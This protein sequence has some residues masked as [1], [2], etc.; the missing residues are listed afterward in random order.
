MW[1]DRNKTY[2]LEKRFKELCKTYDAGFM[3]LLIQWTTSNPTPWIEIDTSEWTNLPK[4]PLPKGGEKITEKPGYLF[5]LNV[6]G[7]MFAG[8]DHYAVIDLGG[9]TRIV[10]WSD[11]PEDEDESY[12]HARV[13]NIYPLQWDEKLQC[14]NT[15]QEQIIYGPT[16]HENVDATRKEWS[17]FRV[18]HDIYI[19]HGIWVS[20]ELNDKHRDIVDTSIVSGWRAWTENIAPEYIRNG[21]VT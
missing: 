1:Y 3:K 9:F 10:C 7:L 2:R 14:M 6:Q 18:P 15:L 16:T 8:F 5:Q 20:D 11:D 17:D 19:R 4:A 21:L 12:R 13:W